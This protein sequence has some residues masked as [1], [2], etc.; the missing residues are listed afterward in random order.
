MKKYFRAALL[1]LLLLSTTIL[2]A[3]S[4]VNAQTNV[5]PQQLH[6]SQDSQDSQQLQEVEPMIIDV[7]DILGYRDSFKDKEFPTIEEIGE[8]NLASFLLQQ[9]NHDMCYQIGNCFCHI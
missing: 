9:F 6:D 5:L 7:E 4:N 8:E 3:C 2:I 1:M